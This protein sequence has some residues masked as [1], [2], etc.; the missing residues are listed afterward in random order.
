MVRQ[1]VRGHIGQIRPQEDIEFAQPGCPY[2]AGFQG[3][4][5]GDADIRNNR[6]DHLVPKRLLPLI[7]VE[8][9]SHPFTKLDPQRRNVLAPRR[10]VTARDDVVSGRPERRLCSGSD[11][12]GSFH[13]VVESPNQLLEQDNGLVLGNDRGIRALHEPLYCLCRMSL[14]DILYNI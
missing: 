6:L 8:V 12:P 14:L 1:D 5:H 3:V 7:R 13:E 2:V 4:N 10:Q 9:V 11:P